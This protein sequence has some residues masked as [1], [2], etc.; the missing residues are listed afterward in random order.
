QLV[1]LSF[2]ILALLAL[3]SGSVVPV[4]AAFFAMV[5]ALIWSRGSVRFDLA[6][7]RRLWLRFR[8]WR[9]ERQLRRRSSKLSVIKGGREDENPPPPRKSQDGRGPWLH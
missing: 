3:T 2:G 1:W 5:G 9:I 6:S 4:L 7:P 8:A